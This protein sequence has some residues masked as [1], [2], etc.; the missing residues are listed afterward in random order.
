MSNAEIGGPA[1]TL[2]DLGYRLPWRK[3]RAE[4]L[5]DLA[6]GS[7][8]ASAMTLEDCQ[9]VPH[10]PS[11]VGDVEEV[12]GVPVLRDKPRRLESVFQLFEA[13]GGRRKGQAH[14]LRHPDRVNTAF[15]GSLQELAQPESSLGG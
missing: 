8:D 9:L 2:D 14:R 11:F 4:R 12:A 13:V 10:G 6:V 5:L 3:P 1:E 7:S 15:V